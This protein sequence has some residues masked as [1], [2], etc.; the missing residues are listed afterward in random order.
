MVERTFGAWKKRFLILS[1]P[2]NY[3][4][5][6]QRNLVFALGILHNFTVDHSGTSGHSFFEWNEQDSPVEDD[7]D[8]DPVDP[9]AQPLSCRQK[10]LLKE[11]R[12]NITQG[13]WDQHQSHLKRHQRQKSGHG[14][15]GNKSVA[16]GGEPVADGNESVADGNKSVADGNELVADGDSLWQM[17][18]S[19]WRMAMSSWQM[20]T[21]LWQMAMS[22]WWVVWG[23]RQ[24]IVGRQA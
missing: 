18:T 7:N 15:D 12:N 8:H 6:M 9:P 5:D 14:A 4:L 16:D 2:L 3:D 21:R 10:A 22:P 24:D 20:A 19:S 17:A 1:H 23:N 11:W 13:P